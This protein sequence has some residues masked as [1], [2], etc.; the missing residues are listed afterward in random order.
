MTKKR[1]LFFYPSNYRAIALETQLRQLRELG[2]E[3]YICTIDPWG[4]LHDY[5]DGQGFRVCALNPVPFDGV[6]Q[7]LTVAWR[8]A[9]LARNL[10]VNII[11]SHLQ[12]ANLAVCIAKLGFSATLIS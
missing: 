7:H 8:I 5:L 1:V 3:V 10:S 11:L 4:Q 12:P 9:K 2:L 6:L